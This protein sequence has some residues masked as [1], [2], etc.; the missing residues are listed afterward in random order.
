MGRLKHPAT[1]LEKSRFKEKTSTKKISTLIKKLGGKKG[2][3]LS[4]LL[5]EAPK[6]KDLM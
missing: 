1:F 4:S 6:Y 2:M 3:L 5:L